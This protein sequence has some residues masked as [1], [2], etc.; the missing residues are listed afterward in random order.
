MERKGHGGPTGG[1]A[2][3]DGG[4]SS[5]P[6]VGGTRSPRGST[7][8]EIKTGEIA[9]E[10]RG[11]IGFLDFLPSCHQR[12]GRK[13]KRGSH[14]RSSASYDPRRGVTTVLGSAGRTAES[15]TRP[16]CGGAWPAADIEGCCRVHAARPP[17]Q[18]R[19]PRARMLTGGLV[20]RARGGDPRWAGTGHRRTSGMVWALP[21]DREPSGSLPSRP[22]AGPLRARH[23]VSHPRRAVGRAAANR[24]NVRAQL[25]R[26]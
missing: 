13:R 10:G 6:S 19:P 25:A 16:A 8:V 7:V 12:R 24:S 5:G 26:R 23:R 22:V 14:P 2:R 3:S 20:S 11:G 18:Q 21:V 17:R 1:T 4:E 15:S 9:G